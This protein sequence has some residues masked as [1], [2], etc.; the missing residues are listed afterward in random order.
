M[1][2]MFFPDPLKKLPFVVKVPERKKKKVN[3]GVKRS[4]KKHRLWLR[5]GKRYI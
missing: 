3:K 1:L 4:L 2:D 5:E